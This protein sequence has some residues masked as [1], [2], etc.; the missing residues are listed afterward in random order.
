MKPASESVFNYK[1]VIGNG[2]FYSKVDIERYIGKNQYNVISVKKR[3]VLIERRDGVK[4][5]K[6]EAIILTKILNDFFEKLELLDD[7][8]D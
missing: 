8:F 6:H 2:Y 7:D 1:I 4:V 5:D 3:N